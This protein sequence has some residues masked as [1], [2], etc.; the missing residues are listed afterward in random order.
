LSDACNTKG[1]WGS[2]VALEFKKRV[3]S[4]SPV[5]WPKLP[6]NL[7]QFPE[8]FKE[9][10]TLCTRSAARATKKN[11]LGTAL[12]ITHEP[13]IGPPEELTNMQNEGIYIACLFTSEGYGKNVD[14][15]DKILE[16]TAKALKHLAPQIHELKRQEEES[17]VEM[18]YIGTFGEKRTKRVL[19]ANR[20][21]R[22]PLRGCRAVRIN[23][24]KFGVPWKKTK[25]VFEDGPLDI[26][27]MRR[28][29]EALESEDDED[30]DSETGDAGQEDEQSIKHEDE[31]E[32]KM[33]EDGDIKSEGKGDIKSE[34]DDIK[35][36]AENDI[37]SEQSA[38]EVGSEEESSQDDAEDD[39][40]DRAHAKMIV[41]RK[42]R[43]RKR[44]SQGR[45]VSR[46]PTPDFGLWP[47]H[48]RRSRARG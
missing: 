10:K 24:G 34:G 45:F 48:Q 25:K 27:V 36:E 5:Q 13:Q 39:L 11:L 26:L 4:Y 31:D 42:P 7:F 18:S 30:S 22:T 37:K 1:V 20:E 21:R 8:A 19:P 38:D 6:T 47:L 44:D 15:P 32:I 17:E 28:E 12:L 41:T 2:G 3:R 9:Y 43:G 14:P 16:N 29:G 35:R 46:P 33:E 23:S 40:L